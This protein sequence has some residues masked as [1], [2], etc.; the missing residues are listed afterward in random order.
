MKFKI[1]LSLTW[2]I[3]IRERVLKQILEVTHIQL[4]HFL[5]A[6]W[7]QNKG[8]LEVARPN[9]HFEMFPVFRKIQ[10]QFYPFVVVI[11]IPGLLEIRG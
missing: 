10:Q 1:L 5:L 7:N 2:L 6:H 3:K 4:F 9:K 11:T 8:E